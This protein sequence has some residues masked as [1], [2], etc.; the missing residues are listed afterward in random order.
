[1]AFKGNVLGIKIQNYFIAMEP[2][3]QFGDLSKYDFIYS[4]YISE[5]Y[6]G[7]VSYASRLNSQKTN[8]NFIEING[9]KL[10]SITFPGNWY[11]QWGICAIE[12]RFGKSTTVSVANQSDYKTNYMYM[13]RVSL[14]RILQFTAENP[15]VDYLEVVNQC[16][17]KPTSKIK[18]EDL[19]NLVSSIEDYISKYQELIKKFTE[20]E[21]SLYSETLKNAVSKNIKNCLDLDIDVD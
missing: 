5:N 15:C 17:Q 11:G 19:R 7:N 21:K 20:E 4:D 1:M 2:V 14:E 3:D 12:D 13:I 18:I 16:I 9:W 6:N 8:Q 10:L